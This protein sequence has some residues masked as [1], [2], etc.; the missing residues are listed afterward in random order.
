LANSRYS[1][2]RPPAAVILVSSG[3][4]PLGSTEK[5]EITQNVTTNFIIIVTTEVLL[6]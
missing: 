2:G 6:K 4:G 3:T 1:V 5:P